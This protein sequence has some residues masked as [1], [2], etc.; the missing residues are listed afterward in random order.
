[1]SQD[2]PTEIMY[3]IKLHILRN[4]GSLATTGISSQDNDL[5]LVV[6]L[7]EVL[8]ACGS[9]KRASSLS[10]LKIICRSG[11]GRGGPRI[12]GVVLSSDG[13]SRCSAATH[14]GFEGSVWRGSAILV[15]DVVGG[16]HFD[17]FY[18]CTAER[19]DVLGGLLVVCAL[20]CSRAGC[21][22]AGWSKEVRALP[23]SLVLMFSTGVAQLNRG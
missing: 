23:T 3:G 13:T 4:L 18:D 5:V 2:I 21:G 8:A 1:M 7:E 6:H 22:L 9:R 11:T 14:Q 16:G 10:N 12:G 19:I 17:D 20:A 15:L